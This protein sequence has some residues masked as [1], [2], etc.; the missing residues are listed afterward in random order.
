MKEPKFSAIITGWGPEALEYLGSDD[1]FVII[2]NEGAPDVLADISILHT[3]SELKANP[4]PGDTLIL[5]DKEYIITDVGWEVPN[6]LRDLG[7][8]AL[9]FRGLAQTER[10][11]TME[12]LGDPLTKEDIKVGGKIEIR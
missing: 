9:S 7:H 11:G 5:C 6:T 12:L 4:L 2:F 3:R 1:A 8:A 10:P